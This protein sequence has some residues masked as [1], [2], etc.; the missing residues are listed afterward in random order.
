MSSSRPGEARRTLL[1]SFDLEDCDQLLARRFGNPAWDRRWAGF[2]RQLDRVLELLDSL[3]VR[4]TF[5]VLGMT[6]RNHGE[7]VQEL[8]SRGHDLA[9]HGFGHEPVSSQSRDEFRRDVER[10]LELIASLT[11]RHAIGYRAPAFSLGRDAAWAFDILADLGVRYDSSLY[12]TPKYR[13]RF[14]GIPEAPCRIE[15]GS[16]R[17][18]WEFP[19]AVARFGPMRVPVGGGSYWRVL[20]RTVLRAL[21]ERGSA[22]DLLPLY[23]HPYECDD[24]A[25]NLPLPQSPTRAQRILAASYWLRAKPGW[26]TL[27][28]RLRWIA[29]DFDLAPYASALE[30]LEHEDDG[31]RTRS[32]SAGGIVV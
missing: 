11:G 24:R 8:A 5:F 23:F 3:G 9:A 25:L 4:A 18:M 31:S 32:L 1:V 20:P 6:A 16:G 26:G 2:E 12:D 30:R 7:W 17:S 28:E 29:R 19:P 22:S 27:P 15:L 21:L 13:G 14:G 10:S